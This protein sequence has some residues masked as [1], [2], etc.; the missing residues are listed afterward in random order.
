VKNLLLLVASA[1]LVLGGGVG[2]WNYKRHDL[3]C[4][5]RFPGMHATP[6]AVLPAH[7][8]PDNMAVCA[9]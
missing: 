7:L 6:I 2:A 8:I 5:Q 3:E 4:Q 1:A 9:R